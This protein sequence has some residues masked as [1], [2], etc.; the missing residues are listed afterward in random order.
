[1][2]GKQREGIFSCSTL[3]VE[4]TRDT[5]LTLISFPL[6]VITEYKSMPHSIPESHLTKLFL[7]SFL[8]EFLLW[9]LGRKVLLTATLEAFDAQ[10]FQGLMTEVRL[11]SKAF[12]KK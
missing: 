1:M 8:Y 11:R 7:V 6:T 12:L 4:I 9:F 10:S 2:N 3:S 5:C